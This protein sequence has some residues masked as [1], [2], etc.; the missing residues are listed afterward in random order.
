LLEATHVNFFTRASLRAVLAAHFAR[1]EVFS[2]GEH[3]VR[4]RDGIALHVHLFAIAEH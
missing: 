1:V 3:P 2:Y 4:T